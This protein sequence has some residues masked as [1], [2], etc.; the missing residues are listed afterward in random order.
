MLPNGPLRAICLRRAC[1]QRQ[2]RQSA[3]SMTIPRVCSPSTAMTLVGPPPTI[4]TSD[5]SH[6]FCSLLSWCGDQCSCVGYPGKHS[7]VWK[8][9][10]SFCPCPVGDERLVSDIS[11]DPDEQPQKQATLEPGADS[12][13]CFCSLL[14]WCASGDQWLIQ[15]SCAGCQGKHSNK[16]D[17]GQPVPK[18]YRKCCV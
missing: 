5:S 18:V 1:W 16:A 2:R 17:V 3:R 9:V 12:S 11:N 4:P 14:S 15:C 7:D 8:W 13:H 10:D 6:C